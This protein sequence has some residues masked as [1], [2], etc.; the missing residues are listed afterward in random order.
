[1]RSKEQFLS[2]RNLVRLGCGILGLLSVGSFTQFVYRRRIR[3]IVPN[4]EFLNDLSLS[5]QSWERSTELGMLNQQFAQK[6]SLLRT[7]LEKKTHPETELTW[8]F[9]FLNKDSYRQ[10][11]EEVERL[12]LFD[13][14][15][16]EKSGVTFKIEESYMPTILTRLS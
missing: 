15:H 6:G 2:R 1:M 16:L 10:W 8:T 5:K 12:G 13:V 3:A 11:R 9:D 7:V 14:A 4:Q